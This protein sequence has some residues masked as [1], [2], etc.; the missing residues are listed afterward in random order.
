M[1]YEDCPQLIRDFLSYMEFVKGRSQ[2]TVKAYYTDLRTFFRF[3]KF[4]KKLVSSDIPFNE[5]NISDITIELINEITL[6][7]VYEFLL[8]VS[9]NR[10]NDNK[11]RARKVSC[12]KVFFKYLTNNK[13]LLKENPVENL[14]APKIKKS[15]PK[16]LNLEECIDILK[17]IDNVNNKRDFCII[18]LFLN[19][20]MR[21]SELCKINLNDIKDD[22]LLLRGKGGKERIVYLN[23]ACI[24]ALSSYIKYRNSKISN[25]KS[26]DKNALFISRNGT[27][28]SPR[29]V[30]MIVEDALKKANL[31]GKG[32]SVHKLR[33]TAATLMYQHSNVD[34]R[35]LQEILGHA[36][37][38]T[39]QIYTHVSDNQ[40]KKA[41][42]STPLSNIKLK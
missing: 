3:I 28:I 4:H 23:Q 27:R 32:Y 8:Y 1:K 39:T 16:Y 24:D 41:I 35:V 10:Q 29:R 13:N 26:T 11:A 2:T 6:S 19:C 33:H 31:D 17:N 25:I 38:G 21:L 15:L 18:T 42:N 12:I 14:E 22:T 36:N 34:V 9:S 20:G 40:V 7:D 30:E 37:L 5:I